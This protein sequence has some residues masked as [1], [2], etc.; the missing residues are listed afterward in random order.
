MVYE[1]PKLKKFWLFVVS[2][3]SPAPHT[4]N[5]VNY[6]RIVE[7]V[8]DNAMVYAG[9]YISFIFFLFHLNCTNLDIL[10]AF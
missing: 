2:A 6:F 1:Q 4:N 3:A 7:I 10:P 8:R 9:F 5:D